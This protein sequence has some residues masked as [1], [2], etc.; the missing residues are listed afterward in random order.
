MPNSLLR[1]LFGCTHRKTT[2]PLT[3]IQRSGTAT[4]TSTESKAQTYIACLDCG[5]EM[6]YD[7]DT[8]RKIKS[9]RRSRR[10]IGIKGKEVCAISSRSREKGQALIETGLILLPLLALGFALLDYS[11]AIF[12]QNVLRNAVREGNRF[13]ITE[14]T[15]GGGQDAAIKAVVQSYSLG[16]LTDPS[17]ISVTDYDKTT[18]LPVTGAGTN[19][20]GNI[21]VVAVTAFPWVAMAPLWR[22]VGY[23]FNAS[24]ADVF[25]AAPNG[26]L[27]LR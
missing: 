9:S 10:Q 4:G 17:T 18:L 16:F 11:L 8:M 1:A 15:G 7:W 13:A 2:F 22:S 26:I 23:S 27:P 6:P 21:C 20:Q 5:E 3:P 14:Q 24:S 12:V 19:A 25:E